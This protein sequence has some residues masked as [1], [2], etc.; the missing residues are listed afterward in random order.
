MFK[1]IIFQILSLVVGFSALF[2]ILY[3]FGFFSLIINKIKTGG[4]TVLFAIIALLFALVLYL[5]SVFPSPPQFALP[6]HM[7]TKAPTGPTAALPLNNS[8]QFFKEFQNFSKIE[9]IG[10]D[11]NNVPAPI[12][13]EDN[14]L[15]KFAITTK[16]VVSE[17]GD[18]TFFNY[19][20]F[21]GQVPGPMLRVK[22]GDDVEISVT[23]DPSSLHAHNIDL[24]SVNGPDGGATLS[25][26]KPGETKTFRFKAMAPG[27]FVYHCATPNISTHNAHGQYD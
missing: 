24:H 14:Q 5:Y 10:A 26:V 2:Y 20:T 23:N 19:W 11:P 18:G 1:Y 13:R 22:E 8:V 25:L 9:N 27:L 6:P 16:E 17:V 12:D 15:V 21:D 4:N 7:Q 3:R